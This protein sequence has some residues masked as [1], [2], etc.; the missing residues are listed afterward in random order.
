MKKID[1]E[2]EN[3]EL[4]LLTL[5]MEQMVAQKNNGHT[6]ELN[7]NLSEL[8]PEVKKYAE[9]VQELQKVFKGD[10]KAV[11]KSGVFLR[12]H[13]SDDDLLPDEEVVD[14]IDHSRREEYKDALEKTKKEKV[15]VS[16]YPLSLKKIKE[17]INDGA[18]SGFNFSFLLEKKVIR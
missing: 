15:K 16:I 9:K 2:L 12:F 1:I 18:L 8:R 7:C 14:V 11:Y 10:K 5:N 4:D 13:E 6:F 17:V 3:H